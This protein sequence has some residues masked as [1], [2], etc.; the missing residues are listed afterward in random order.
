MKLIYLH[1][2]PVR[3]WHWINAFCMI[4]LILTAL[5]IRYVGIINVTSF[6]T[7][8]VVHNWTGFVI[9]GNYFVW[10]LFHLNSDKIK[11]W[12]PE[13]PKTYFPGAFRQMQFYAYG[14]FVGDPNPFHVTP[15]NK[16]NPLQIVLYQVIMLLV[17]PIQF[18][19]GI[20]LWDVKHFSAAVDLLGGVRVV[21]TVH[22]LI[23]IFF[24]F[25]IQMHIYLATLGHTPLAHIRAMFTG[26]EEEFDEHDAPPPGGKFRGDTQ[27]AR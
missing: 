5:Q 19:T 25:F 24:I 21:D 6:H 16:F 18:V 2:L 22:V 20:L 13:R 11:A 1:P 8:V 15:L 9:I 3:I 12:L 10:L 27:R 26:Y 4:L 23:F 17:L 14:I 7:A